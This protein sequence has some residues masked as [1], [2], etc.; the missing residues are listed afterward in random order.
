M[1]TNKKLTLCLT[2]AMVLG[3][4]TMAHATAL[5]FAFDPSGGGS[6]ATTFNNINWAAADTLAVGGNPSGGLITNDS[7]HALYQANLANITGGNSGTGFANGT[8][9]HF[10]TAVA[11]FYELATV[12]GP[13]A[14]FS[15][16]VNEPSFFKI[17]ATS[18]EGTPLTGVG[19]TNPGPGQPILTGHIVNVASQPFSSVFVVT[20]SSPTVALDQ[21]SGAA[22]WASTTTVVGSGSTELTA[23]IDAVN[24]HYF[25]DLLVG[26]FFTFAAYSTNTNTPFKHVDPSL[27]FSNDGITSAN[28]I[29]DVGT[30]NGVLQSSK[31]LDF[32]FESQGTTSF[33]TTPVPEPSTLL[34]IGFGLLGFAV[35]TRRAK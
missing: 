30:K 1:T 28:Q 27:A 12:F 16:L 29:T 13:V 8:G 14:N 25:P 19:F 31:D 33:F 24:K 32:I 2:L 7:V 9:T 17:Y 23:Q 6:T 18:A 3:A 35:C 5:T 34:L 26:S 4:A 20:Q 21:F 10:F 22:Q 15:A 11:G